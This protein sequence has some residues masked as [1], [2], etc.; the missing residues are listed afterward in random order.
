MTKKEIT[1]L[2]AEILLERSAILRIPMKSTP[3][4]WE[5]WKKPKQYVREFEIHPLTLAQQHRIVSRISQIDDE[6]LKGEVNVMQIYSKLIKENLDDVIY[7]VGVLLTEPRKEPSEE[8]LKFIKERF[9]NEDLRACWNVMSQQLRVVPFLS[10][11]ISIKGIEM[12]PT[13]A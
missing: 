11:I 7:C 9:N 3:K 6:V 2:E 8:L 13:T 12:N 5:F 4:W 1:Q 10:G